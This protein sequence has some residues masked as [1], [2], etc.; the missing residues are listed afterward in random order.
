MK[1]IALHLGPDE[2][3]VGVLTLPEGTRRPVAALLLNA[4]VV[5]RIGPHRTNLKIARHLARQGYTAIRFDI[6]GVGDSRPPRDAAPFRQQ[7]VR[8]IQTVM[9]Y[10]QRK[11]G[12]NEFALYG[13]CAGAMNAYATALIDI[14]VVGVFMIDGYAYPTFKSHLVQYAARIRAHAPARLPILLARRTGRLLLSLLRRPA[15][16]KQEQPAPTPSSAPTRAQFATAIQS[17]VD[18]GVQIAMIFSGSVF[19]AYSYATQLH[20]GF[21]R[22]RF[23]ERVIYHHAPEIDHLVTPLQAQRRV[24][25]LVDDW[26]TQTSLRTKPLGADGQAASE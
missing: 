10:L 26:I 19:S 5:H 25:E 8:D 17:M 12:L 24:L 2:N 9:D 7:A 15:G 1:E 18:R 23:I 11:H 16:A 3:L 4:G 21:R 20:D 13:I 6:S 14:R 22:H